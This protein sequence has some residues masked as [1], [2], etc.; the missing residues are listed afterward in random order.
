[1]PSSLVSPVQAQL[2]KTD[3]A[4]PR[5]RKVE[6]CVPHCGDGSTAT[7]LADGV[8]APAFVAVEWIAGFRSHALALTTVAEALSRPNGPEWKKALLAEVGSH[9]E[10]GV[11]EACEL[12]RGLR[13]AAG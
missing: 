9:L 13:A 2:D 10:L 11:W 12:P 4:E 6:G 3:A 8:I 1:V 5:G 7:T